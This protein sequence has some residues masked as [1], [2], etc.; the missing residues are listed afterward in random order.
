MKKIQNCLWHTTSDGNIG[1]LLLRVFIA[2]ALLTHG[3][4]KLTAG[5]ELWGQLGGA[6]TG[7]GVPGP[8]V[9]WGFMAAFAESIGSI[10]LLV[11]LLT[12]A[13][14]ALIAVTM[15]VA[16]FVVH[17]GQGFA[18]RELALL[19]L[20]PGLLFMLKGAGRYSLDYLLFRRH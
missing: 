15:A 9:F 3:L 18:G 12:P 5:P 2:L 11:G 4:P 19:Y 16:A 10:M 13:A 6:V 20:F 17:G 14:A 8:A 7:L 1:Y